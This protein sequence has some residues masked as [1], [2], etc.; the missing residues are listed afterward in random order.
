MKSQWV[1]CMFR[2]WIETIGLFDI[3]LAVGIV[4][5]S[6]PISFRNGVDEVR[7]M[8]FKSDLEA[9]VLQVGNR[10][11]ILALRAGEKEVLC[12]VLVTTPSGDWEVELASGT[13]VIHYEQKRKAMAAAR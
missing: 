6:L 8:I 5:A 2:H 12:Q 7:E 3:Q 9:Q 4:S 13:Q 1:P 10:W 11:V